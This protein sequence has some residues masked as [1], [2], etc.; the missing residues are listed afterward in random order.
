MEGKWQGANNHKFTKF[1][2]IDLECIILIYSYMECPHLD[3]RLQ[4]L[5]VVAHTHAPFVHES[6]AV[7]MHYRGVYSFISPA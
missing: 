6:C 1:F 5:A 3:E 4:N 7:A 2:Q